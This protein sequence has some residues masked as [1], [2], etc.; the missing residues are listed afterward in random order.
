MF[1]VHTFYDQQSFNMTSGCEEYLEE[2]Q[3]TNYMYMFN[4]NAKAN[5]MVI[6]VLCRKA[7]EKAFLW[8]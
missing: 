8:Y 5:S 6:L 1:S 4:E 7:W 2:E 3:S